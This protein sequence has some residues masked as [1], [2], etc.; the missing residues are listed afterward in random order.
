MWRTGDLACIRFD[1]LLPRLAPGVPPQQEEGRGKRE[2]S[3]YALLETSLAPE[4]RPGKHNR[5]SVAETRLSRF[6]DTSAR[7]S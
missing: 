1:V 6:E 5:K 3:K 4:A 2:M 7:K